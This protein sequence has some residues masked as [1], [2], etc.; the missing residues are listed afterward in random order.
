[1]NNLKL[2]IGS[3]LLALLAS[4]AVGCTAQL[5]GLSASDLRD[6]HD[7]CSETILVDL[8]ERLARPDVLLLVDQSQSMVDA[9]NRLPNGSSRWSTMVNGIGNLMGSFPD[10]HFGLSLFPNRSSVCGSGGVDV[11]PTQNTN[12][13]VLSQIEGA[14]PRGQTPT[15][16]TLA[17]ALDFYQN[18]TSINNDGRYVLLATD[19][20]DSCGGNPALT[21]QR[22]LDIGVKTFV[23]GFNDG[24]IGF[25]EL[26]RIA[27]SGGTGDFYGIGS[28]EQLDQSL[29]EILGVVSEPSCTLNL[30]DRPVVEEALSLNIGG[31]DVGPGD[32]GWSYNSTANRI[33]LTGDACR[34]LQ[35]SNEVEVKVDLGC[36][37]V[38]IE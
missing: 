19:G 2:K 21:A 38:Q 18:Q 34:S 29:T 1:M 27:E 4:G 20:N 13:S 24:A 32:E 7:D 15:A 3:V 37:S 9:N 33:V 14:S 17:R 31:I 35:N 26:R 25:E 28:G 5:G 23:I 10:V 22:L 6:D 16:A 30:N 12:E 11:S 8:E 36:S